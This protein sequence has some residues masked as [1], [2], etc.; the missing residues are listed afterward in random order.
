MDMNNFYCFK[1]ALCDH[2]FRAIL[3]IVLQNCNLSSQK[4]QKSLIKIKQISIL[5]GVVHCIVDRHVCV[6]KFAL[7]QHHVYLDL[8]MSLLISVEYLWCERCIVV[9]CFII[10]YMTT[11]NTAATMTH[12][13]V[14]T[15]SYLPWLTMKCTSIS[16]KM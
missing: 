14:I 1:S 10:L 6:C 5:S 11:S 8:W 9:H 16:S 2:T 12:R 7:I 15:H 13:A 4:R 3:Y